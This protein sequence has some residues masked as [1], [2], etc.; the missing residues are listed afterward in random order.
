[1]LPILPLTALLL[2]LEPCNFHTLAWLHPQPFENVPVFQGIAVPPADGLPYQDAPNPPQG[3]LQ[4]APAP[5]PSPSPEFVSRV[6]PA[7]G[8][9][10]LTFAPPP[11]LPHPAP[12]QWGASSHA[13]LPSGLQSRD[14]FGMSAASMESNSAISLNLFHP[15]LGLIYIASPGFISGRPWI[16]GRP[17]QLYLFPQPVTASEPG[18]DQSSVQFTALHYQEGYITWMT[19]P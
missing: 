12:E 5:L 6:Q 17:C 7:T 8:L 11:L 9:P 1:M 16:I 14:S 13:I 18:F 19:Q 4:P 15:W 2:S 3:K 10:P